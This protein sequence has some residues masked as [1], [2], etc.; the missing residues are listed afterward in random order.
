[1]LQILTSWPGPRPTTAAS[2][3][4]TK[5]AGGG[6]PEDLRNLTL[7][8]PSVNRHQKR[9][10]DASEWQPPMNRYWFANRVVQVTRA[11]G[12]SV[13]R[14][15]R[16]TLVRTL[17]GC[18]D[19]AIDMTPR[20]NRRGSVATG[21]PRDGAG[22]RR[23]RRAPRCTTT[24]ETAGSRAPRRAATASRRCR[25]HT[26]RTGT[27]AGRRRRWR[28][29]R[30]DLGTGNASRPPDPGSSGKSRIKRGRALQR[31]T[32]ARAGRRGF[33]SPPQRRPRDTGPQR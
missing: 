23:H 22:Q 17:A 2:A 24:T 33:P 11:Y 7:A 8:A 15:E 26:R 16:D 30:V 6:S 3:G 5:R 28:G 14:R 29:L 31:G 25:R 13:Y 32:P 10:H 12:L 9:D 1:M 4:P 18:A 20:G 19:T 27:D 21:R